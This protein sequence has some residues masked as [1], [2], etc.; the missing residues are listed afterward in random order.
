MR[1]AQNT[2]S[3]WRRSSEDTPLSSNLVP[4]RDYSGLEVQD[5]ELRIWLPDA[6]KQ[7]LAEICARADTTMTVYLTEF[8]A[9]YLYGLH[10]VMRMRDTQ[11]GLYKPVE[12]RLGSA[13]GLPE[14]EQEDE[15]DP[16]FDEP[17]PEMGKNIFQLKLFLPSKIKAGL[18]QRA[19]QGDVALG[20]FVRAM[21]CAHLFG[22]DVGPNKL[23]KGP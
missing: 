3:E 8:F 16:S 21:I 19:D 10:E 2:L 23:M 15:L 4:E 20:R 5:S 6:A 9:L 18:Q 11:H 22:R 12:R 13:F 17:V 7:A 1:I 14:E